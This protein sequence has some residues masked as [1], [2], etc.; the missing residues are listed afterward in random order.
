MRPTHVR[1]LPGG[2]PRGPRRSR[3]P[4]GGGASPLGGK[5]GVIGQVV[6]VE[7]GVR[8]VELLLEAGLRAGDLLG[9]GGVGEVAAAVVVGLRG[10]RKET[11]RSDG[12]GR[13]KTHNCGSTDHLA[14]GPDFEALPQRWNPGSIVARF[15]S[16]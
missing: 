16:T 4:A 8:G 2:T 7:E 6:G 3:L 1:P 12:N 13:K 14:T 9:E 10:R 5:A 11:L 15:F